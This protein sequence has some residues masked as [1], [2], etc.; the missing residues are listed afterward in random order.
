MDA[1]DGAGREGGDDARA[2]RK[3]PSR[4]LPPRASADALTERQKRRRREKERHERKR[5]SQLEAAT[6]PGTGT[7][8]CAHTAEPCSNPA[9]PTWAQAKRARRKAPGTATDAA[10]DAD[11]APD[12][13]KVPAGTANR[14]RTARSLRKA[15]AFVAVA[16]DCDEAHAAA[17]AAIRDDK[18][19]E[20]LVAFSGAL[21]PVKRG[22]GLGDFL[23]EIVHVAGADFEHFTAV[24]RVARPKTKDDVVPERWFSAQ[25]Q[26]PVEV[27]DCRCFDV[28]PAADV[29][30]VNAA[31]DAFLRAATAKGPLPKD[32]TP[33][34]GSV[35]FV[36]SDSSGVFE[37]VRVL[38]GDSEN[39]RTLKCGSGKSYTNV[40]FPHVGVLGCG[41]ALT[42]QRTLV[43]DLR[44][45]GRGV[46]L[47]RHLKPIFA[48]LGALDDDGN[49]IVAH[50][51]V[52][53]GH[54]E[55]E[56][57]L[58]PRLRQ[59]R[60]R[61]GICLCIDDD[62]DRSIRSSKRNLHLPLIHVIVN[63]KM[64]CTAQ[65]GVKFGSIWLS[66]S[67][68]PFCKWHRLR[69]KSD[70]QLLLAAD[71]DDASR[72]DALKRLEVREKNRKS[73]LD[74]FV[75]ITS[76]CNWLF[77][78]QPEVRVAFENPENDATT[79]VEY[80]QMAKEVFGNNAHKTSGAAYNMRIADDLVLKLYLVLSRNVVFNFK[81]AGDYTGETVPLE[82]SDMTKASAIYPT[83]FAQDIATGLCPE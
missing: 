71:T 42:L 29:A 80:Q 20:H 64:L 57:E 37:A 66:P 69:E 51:T 23:V 9:P 18:R 22:A 58:L 8:P 21:L 2:G 6:K 11:D 38:A 41:K 83:A 49:L 13:K 62:S 4:D 59:S 65:D 36:Q 35:V 73:A 53:A 30:K 44:P 60:R 46:S 75:W 61:R 68:G 78:G 52:G 7:A 1:C 67:C 45:L 15:N 25:P 48:A 43:L 79:H 3:R 76:F 27:G 24:A 31:K 14:S 70:R 17:A 63:C 72:E 19:R 5:Q 16:V 82:G 47:A 54:K 34:V 77:E 74:V 50:M 33:A 32:A 26:E 10:V 39:T 28:L 40:A 81:H 56:K 55:M 12:G